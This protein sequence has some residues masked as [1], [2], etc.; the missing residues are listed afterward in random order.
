MPRIRPLDP[1]AAEGK[2]KQLL[3]GVQKAL[4]TTPNLM[5][6][7]AHSPAALGAYLGFG[8][9]LGGASLDAKT[10]EAIALTVAGLNGCDYCASAHSAIGAKLGAE[11]GELSLNLAG[12][13]GDPKVQAILDFAQ[14]VVVKRGWVSD[15]DLAAAHAAGLGD[16]EIAEVVASVALNI[17]TNYFNHI[18]ATEVDFPLVETG[19][20][21]AA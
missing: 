1:A 6:S 5:R 12:R 14:A 15:Q 9:A 19:G 2:A 8:Q 7:L 4:G 18:A 21:A 20:K 16:G 17:F 10:R 11:P 3:D 13:S